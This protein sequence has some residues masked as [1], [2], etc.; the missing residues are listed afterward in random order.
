VSKKTPLF[1]AHQSAGAKLVD[2]AG[3]QMPLHYGSQ[4]D[5]HHQVRQ[6]V[7]LFDVSHMGVVDLSGADVAAYLRKLLAN[8]I[9]K[10]V[11][12]QALYTCMLNEKGGVIDD[13]IVY[14]INQKFYRLV[15]NAGCRENDVA[16]MR[17][18]L[19]NFSVTL[20]ER[21]DLSMIAIQGPN[22]DRVMQQWLPADQ[23]AALQTLKAFHFLQLGEHFI[24]KTGYT[25]EQGYEIIIAEDQAEQIWQALIDYGAKPCGLGA[26]DTLRLEAG[27]NLYGQDMDLNTT[28]LESNL[29]WTVAMEPADRH[30]VGRDA[31]E[32]QQNQGMRQKLVGLVLEGAGIMRHD[33]VV[34]FDENGQGQITSGGYSPTLDKSIAL[35]RVPI[36]AE[37]KCSV[38]IRKQSVPAIIVKP[39]FVRH[40]KKMY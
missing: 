26:R 12:G 36:D 22:T 11:D 32:A 27:L 40:G 5:E 2:F 25:G 18:H 4:I 30:F 39:P 19:D 29:A 6:N 16:W 14:R 28:P 3:W 35:A 1:L 38:Q 7:G 8:N 10:L 17:V 34:N 15:I 37:E 21:T 23:Y 20:T 9:D 31:L 13:L 24:A 33:M